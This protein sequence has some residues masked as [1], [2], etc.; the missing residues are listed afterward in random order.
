VGEFDRLRVEVLLWDVEL[1]QRVLYEG[2]RFQSGE[3]A[4]PVLSPPSALRRLL[5]SFLA[6]T[7]VAPSGGRLREGWSLTPNRPQVNGYLPIE[8]DESVQIDGEALVRLDVLNGGDRTEQGGQVEVLARRSQRLAMAENVV[9]NGV[10][11]CTVA[12]ALG[13]SA[14]LLRV[15]FDNKGRLQWSAF[16]ANGDRLTVVARGASPDDTAQAE[17]ARAVAWHD[18]VLDA[19]WA[20]RARQRRDDPL[21]TLSGELAR[22]VR[23]LGQRIARFRGVAATPDELSRRFDLLAR[24]C[25]CSTAGPIL[26]DWLQSAAPPRWGIALA[27]APAIR[28]RWTGFAATLEAFDRE[29]TARRLDRATNEFLYWVYRHWDLS[30]LLPHLKPDLDLVLEVEGVLHAVPAAFL[31]VGAWL[32]ERVRSVRASLSLLITLLHDAEPGPAD[33]G[34][35]SLITVSWF[36]P[37][38]QDRQAIGRGEWWLYAGQ[39]YLANRERMRWRTASRDPEG[40]AESIREGLRG[41]TPVRLLTVC[42]HGCAS[43]AGVHLR[44]NHAWNG[45]GCDFSRVDWLLLVSCS[46]GRLRQVP[47]GP[48][49]PDVTGFVANLVAQRA[50]AALACRWPV[51]AI[52]APWFANAVADEYLDSSQQTGRADRAAALARARRKFFGNAA[53]A[54][55]VIGLN[56]LAAFE[57]YGEG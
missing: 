16:R 34:E 15:G 43:P 12:S 28:E 40:S 24:A 4:A 45:L 50:R 21:R 55:G 5:P 32:F 11:E 19:I 36:D 20:G 2:Y 48:V 29:S 35:S 46:V 8:D 9:R 49:V 39:C 3:A 27:D 47:G 51:H 53:K 7:P 52:Q 17:I 25:G 26:L 33:C 38:D 6:G 18:K 30:P 13:P 23:E 37:V 42:G 44:D 31:P 56:T 54:Y 1:G 14:V 10:D 57:L 41:G 22:E